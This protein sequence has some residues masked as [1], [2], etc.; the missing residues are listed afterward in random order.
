MSK[1]QLNKTTAP[2]SPAA[3]KVYVYADAT[4]GKIKSKDESG[5]VSDFEG[6][7]V[8]T[9]ISDYSDAKTYALGNQVVYDNKLWK[10]TTAVTV[11]EAWNAGKWTELSASAGS[12]SSIAAG[13]SK[14]EV[15]DSG[16]GSIV[17]TIDNVSVV[18]IG[19]GTMSVN[20]SIT[21]KLII[22]KGGDDLGTFQSDSDNFYI[23]AEG[24]SKDLKLGTNGGNIDVSAERVTNVADPVGNQDATNK[25]YVDDEAAKKAPV[26]VPI[27]VYSASA[28]YA[29][30]DQVVEADKLFRCTTAIGTPE[31]FSGSNWLEISA[32]SFTIDATVQ[33]G[34]NNP[35]TGNAVYDELVLK[36]SAKSPI[37]AYSASATYAIGDQ[38]V[39]SDKIYRCTTAVGAPEAFN[40][41]KWTEISASAGVTID[42]SIQDGSSNPVQNNAIHDALALKADAVK[43]ISI[44]SS[45]ATY[46]VGDQVIYDD[47]IYRCINPISTPEAWTV[48]HWANISGQVTVVDN[49]ASSSATDALSANQGNALDNSKANKLIPIRDYSAVITYNIGEIVVYNDKIWRCST[50]IVSGEAWNVSKWTEISAST[51]IDTDKIKNATEYAQVVCSNDDQI[52]VKLNNTFAGAFI[53]SGGRYSLAIRDHAGDLAAYMYGA[54]A[55]QPSEVQLNEAKNNGVASVIIKPPAALTAGYTL[56][57]PDGDGENKQYL[58]TDGNGVTSWQPV[59]NDSIS[60]GNADT[61]PSENAVFDALVLKADESTVLKKDGSVPIDSGSN[62]QFTGV[63]DG[64]KINIGGTSIIGL[65]T[66]NLVVKGPKVKIE[67]ATGGALVATFDED[68]LTM[69]NEKITGLVNGAASSDAVA[70]NQVSGKDD[71]KTQAEGGAPSIQMKFWKGTQAQYNTIGVPDGDTIYYII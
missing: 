60:N 6:A 3:G 16:S 17:A 69:N 29:I 42:A 45:S 15:T 7:S 32:T 18:E 58:R 30:G 31:A 12:P 23:K 19:S 4:D 22:K 8:E 41:T 48:G 2:D 25:K 44:Y 53:Y 70:Y 57:L 20:H 27:P 37:P 55:T 61:A 54:T 62:I 34:S 26:A 64:T 71:I 56:T 35:P 52:D 66:G 40:G 11:A 68:G 24:L 67:E 9:P 13:D 36:A 43:P 1:I 21:P 10:C 49:L 65:D 33:D 46:S 47:H 38:V 39:E 63:T 50:A 51:A 28:T 59:V 5:T 14:V